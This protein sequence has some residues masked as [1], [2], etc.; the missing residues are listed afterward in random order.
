MDLRN[1][2]ATRP[3]G[4]PTRLPPSVRAAETCARITVLS[5]ICVTRVV[6]FSSAC[7]AKA[8]NAPALPSRSNRF[9]TLLRLPNRSESAPGEVVDREVRQCFEE[10]PVILDHY[11]LQRQVSSVYP[12]RK[13]QFTT[14]TFANITESPCQS[15]FHESGNSNRV[16]LK[17][18]T[19]VNSPISREHIRC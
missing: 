6:R 8:S 18:G 19:R 12:H 11:A 4:R 13:H 16:D 17:N 1:E 14:L 7:I 5:K 15:A 2:P 10:Q 3:A 9:R